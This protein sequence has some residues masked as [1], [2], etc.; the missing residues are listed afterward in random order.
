MKNGEAYLGACY[1]HIST[2][3]TVQ[4]VVDTGI[5]FADWDSTG[6]LILDPPVAMTQLTVNLLLQYATGARGAH[7]RSHLS[8]TLDYEIPLFP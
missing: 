8:R 6:G 1:Q 5:L 3:E 7:A 2:L 4:E